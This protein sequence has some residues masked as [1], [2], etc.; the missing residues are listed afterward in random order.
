MELALSLQTV[1]ALSSK[2]QLQFDM[3]WRVGDVLPHKPAGEAKMEVLQNLFKASL[4]FHFIQ[5]LSVLKKKL[6]SIV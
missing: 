4:F 1:C 5:C 6:L 2:R 3:N